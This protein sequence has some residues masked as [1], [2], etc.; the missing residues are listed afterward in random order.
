[1]KERTGASFHTREQKK[2]ICTLTPSFIIDHQVV[3]TH[4]LQDPFAACLQSMNELKFSDLVNDGTDLKLLDAL[5]LIRYFLFPLKK[6]M[7]GIQPV[8]KMLEW[9][10][11]IFHFTC[12]NNSEAN[13]G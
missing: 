3:F 5:P 8:D 13:S 7:Q 1:M 2:I 4:I 6:H 9:L 10:H 11:W 12:S